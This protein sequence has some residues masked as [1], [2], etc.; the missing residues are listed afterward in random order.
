MD[1]TTLAAPAATETDPT[2]YA[3]T[4]TYAQKANGTTQAHRPSRKCPRVE[5][6]TRLE[7]PSLDHV[8]AAELC[9][10]CTNP[11]I[12]GVTLAQD[13]TA[14]DRAHYAEEARKMESTGTTATA[15]K[16]TERKGGRTKKEIA[17]EM[18]AKIEAAARE[19]KKFSVIYKE[20]GAEAA[21][22]TYARLVEVAKVA[23]TPATA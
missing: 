20:V 9:G 14:R 8:A 17:P 12:D 2:A 18:V 6:Q 16:T 3:L 4:L 11:E 15:P 22:V 21:G 1:A 23:K 5:S 7:M 13:I 10:T 19:G